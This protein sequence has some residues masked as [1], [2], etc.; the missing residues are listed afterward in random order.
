MFSASGLGSVET[1]A[2]WMRVPRRP[3]HNL[4]TDGAHTP[5]PAEAE[6]GQL[7][8][9]RVVGGGVELPEVHHAA[10]LGDGAV[11]DRLATALEVAANDR[12]LDRRPCRTV[13]AGIQLGDRERRGDEGVH[14]VAGEPTV[15]GQRRARGSSSLTS[16]STWKCAGC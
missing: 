10:D 6:V 16:R 9:R 11:G 4:L 5:G 3:S 14:A 2:G 8:V 1:S 15:G 7:G 13:A 12:A